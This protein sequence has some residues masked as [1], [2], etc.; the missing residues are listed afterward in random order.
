[1]DFLCL[2]NWYT[3]LIF[4]IIILMFLLLFLYKKHSSERF[5]LN[6]QINDMTSK[7]VYLIN[8]SLKKNNVLD[9]L[10]NI[11]INNNNKN[12]SFELNK[13]INNYKL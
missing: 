6:E 3:L 11:L 5:Y 13:D 4:I 7:L 1:M 2:F 9:K 12:I 8:D 10:T